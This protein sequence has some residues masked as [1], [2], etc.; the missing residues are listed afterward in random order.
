[1]R[2]SRSRGVFLVF[3]GYYRWNVIAVIRSISIYLV[4]RFIIAL[5]L[6]NALT[7][8]YRSIPS[9]LLLSYSIYYLWLQH[10]HITLY[11]H[12]KIM[13]SS[14]TALPPLNSQERRTKL[15]RIERSNPRAGVSRGGFIDYAASEVP[16]AGY[17]IK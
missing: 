2:L 10:S 5:I 8:I 11:R 6:P 14:D 7:N 16:L 4:S 13:S 9:T 3:S 15:A 17:Y 12:R 1:M